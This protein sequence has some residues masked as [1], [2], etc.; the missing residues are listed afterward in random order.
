MVKLKVIR[1]F[2]TDKST[3][4]E[5][6]FND[7]FF[8]YTLEDE[9]KLGKGLPKVFGETAIPKGKYKVIVDRSN[10]FSKLAGKDVFL[11]LLVDVPDYQG[12]RLHSG[13]KPEDTEGCILLG[14]SH[15]IET[16]NFI[17]MSKI[18]M[19]KLMAKLVQGY[20]TNNKGETVAILIDKDI[21]IE[22]T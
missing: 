19:Q 5:L 8:A 13:N 7:V 22:I 17:G 11:P 3:I 1:K 2:F 10:R 20:T 9:D 6:Y 21:T 18:A 15:D 4:G 14:L 12:V 16:P